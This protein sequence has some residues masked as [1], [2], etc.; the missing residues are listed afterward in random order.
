MS[1]RRNL[2]LALGTTL[3]ATTA[4]LL[5]NW[6][7][8]PLALRDTGMEMGLPAD[9]GAASKAPFWHKAVAVTY[10]KPAAVI[11]GTSRAAAGLDDAHPGFAENAKPVYNLSLAGA[12]IAQMRELLV[13][14]HSIRPLR[15]AVLGLD[16]EAFLLSGRTDFDPAVL[17]GN[18]D[19][20]PEWMNRMRLNLSW[21]ALTATAELLG[22]ERRKRK[23]RKVMIGERV[24]FQIAEF[25]NFHSRVAD[26]FPSWG[27]G[28]RWDT[29]PRRA[30]SMRAFRDLVSFAREEGIDLR[31]FI[32]PTHARYL[33]LYRRVGWWAIFEEWKRALV[34]ALAEEAG[35]RP[36]SEV[37]RL[38][39]FSGFN[40]VT[41]E[42]LPPPTDLETTMRWHD[43][44]SHYSR[45]HGNLILERVL[46]RPRA[47]DHGPVEVGV[48][49]TTN[50]IE[51]HLRRTRTDAD[52]YRAAFPADVAEV[53][54]IVQLIRRIAR[55]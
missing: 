18:K 15:Q 6:H 47:R 5:T 46:D 40:G 36:G 49:I 21:R 53:G 10:V 19:S 45:E 1:P 8:D 28:V 26:L 12:S 29:D 43:D 37:F 11:L 24:A 30:A 14:A 38:W 20:A 23:L 27:P 31:L 55:R 51:A 2:G 48:L 41:M 52:G 25:E 16:L 44:S 54:M 33:E 42:A 3:V 4:I 9:G 7:V 22:P 35:T 32:S 13:H 17:A 39:D 34:A 50:N